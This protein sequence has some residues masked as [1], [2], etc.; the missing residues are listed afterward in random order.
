M[1]AAGKYVQL[2]EKELEFMRQQ[3]SLAR[4]DIELYRGKCER[5]ELS[6]MGQ[7]L[8]MQEFV[9][10]TDAQTKAPI[11]DVKINQERFQTP[12]RIPFSDLKRRWNAMTQEEQDK[13]I[14]DGWE[15]EAK[16]KEEANAGQ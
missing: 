10:R 1:K 15:V 3:L 5:L 13:A 4:K 14:E 16:P 12:P 6:I 11:K 7:P 2:L 8:V 9:A